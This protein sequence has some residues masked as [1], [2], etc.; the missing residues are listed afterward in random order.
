MEVIP[1]A[2]MLQMTVQIGCDSGTFEKYLKFATG[3]I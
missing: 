2:K 3:R 1:E